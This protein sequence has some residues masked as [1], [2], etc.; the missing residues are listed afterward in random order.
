MLLELELD[1]FC[2]FFHHTYFLFFFSNRKLLTFY[3]IYLPK[4]LVFNFIS[5]IF[6]K[7]F[8]LTSPRRVLNGLIRTFLPIKDSFSHGVLILFCHFSRKTL[9]AFGNVILFSL[10]QPLDSN[11]YRSTRVSGPTRVLPSFKAK[12]VLWIL[13]CCETRMSFS[14]VFYCF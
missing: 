3:L 4:W 14:F 11:F 10:V 6:P 1:W 2:V 7:C 9:S 5:L 13:L 12:S 8:S